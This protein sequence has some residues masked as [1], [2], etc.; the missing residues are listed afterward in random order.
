MSK[1]LYANWAKV[2]RSKVF[3]IAEIFLIGY[4]IFVYFMG[5]I[6]QRHMIIIP[7][8][9]WTLY[10][11]NEMLFIHAI[12]AIFTVFFIGVEYSDGAIRNKFVIGHTR[13]SVYLS[14][15]IMCCIVGLIQFATYS[16]TSVLSG[17]MLIGSNTFMGMQQLLWRFF[18]SI[19][20]IMAYS[21]LFSMIAMLDSNKTRAVVVG[22]VLVFVYVMLMTQIWSDLAEPE[23]TSRAVLTETGE[24]EIEEDIP[25]SKYV[26]GTKRVVYEWIDAFLPMDQ[27]M[28]VIDPDASFSMKAPL[29]LLGETILFVGVG[30]YVF[31]R[32]D[33]K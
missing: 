31:Q 8:S 19:L 25:N 5:F 21:A 17:W 6:N 7:D 15:F 29:C 2:I 20:I 30:M 4:S 32:K 9:G 3:W 24:L 10:F 23:R 26:S 14:N 22:L 27:A 16:I 1:L 33:L 18:Y 11:F 13:K 28:Y 12:T